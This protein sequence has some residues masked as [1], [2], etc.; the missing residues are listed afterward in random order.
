MAGEAGERATAA[1]TTEAEATAAQASLESLRTEVKQTVHALNNSLGVLR[2]TADLLDQQIVEPPA[3]A[4]TMRE[5][6]AEVVK[7]VETLRRTAQDG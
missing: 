4:Q 7:I 2:L 6:L 3:A 1:G 5:E